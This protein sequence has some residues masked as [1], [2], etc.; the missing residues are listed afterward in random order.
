MVDW[1]RNQVKEKI[2][3]ALHETYE[4]LVL[5]RESQPKRKRVQ[6]VGGKRRDPV[7]LCKMPVTTCKMQVWC[8]LK[9]V[10]LEETWKSKVE[11]RTTG[12]M[13]VANCETLVKHSP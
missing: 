5:K 9:L 1:M 2:G 12:E 3:Q 10:N 6:N 13:R 4:T 11:L 7:P 8:R